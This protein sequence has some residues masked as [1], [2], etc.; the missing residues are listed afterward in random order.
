MARKETYFTVPKGVE[1]FDRDDGKVF[2]IREM[3]ALQAEKWA[4][5][6]FL[7]LAK[8]GVDIPENIATAGFAGVAMVGL[9]SLG[10]VDFA[11]AEPLLDE[12]LTC[13]QYVPD[14]SK[15]VIMRADF[16]QAGDIEE[17]PTFLLLRREVFELHSN[18]SALAAR[19]A[20][21]RPPKPPE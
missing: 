7:A 16:V 12:L 17:V 19:W 6:A 2:F 11:E 21:T 14:P 3:P 15:P 13:V 10:G 18:F 20:S 8:A 1:G 9:A 4:M 5:R